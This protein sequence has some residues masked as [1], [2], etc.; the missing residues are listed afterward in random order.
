MLSEDY[1]TLLSNVWRDVRQ[2]IESLAEDPTERFAEWRGREVEFAREVLGQSL[3]AAQRSQIR[4]FFRNRFTTI[5]ASRRSSKTYTNAICIVIAINLYPCTLISLGPTERQVKQQLWQNVALIYQHAKRRGVHLLGKLDT[6]QLVVGPAHYALGFST[7]RPDRVQGAHA[8]ASP[9]LDDP[10]RDLTDDELEAIRRAAER[11][12]GDIRKLFY[13]LDEAA[14]IPQPIID[15]ILGST[16]SPNVHLMLTANPTRDYDDDHEFCRSFQPGSG[17]HRIKISP[18]VTEDPVEF[19][20]AFLRVPNWL[21]EPTWPEQCARKWGEDSP[22]Y[23]AY[24]AGNFASDQAGSQVIPLTILRDALANEVNADVGLHMG[25]DIARMGSDKS[26]ASLWRN[27]RQVAYHEWGKS[28]LMRSYEIVEDLRHKWGTR[29]ADGELIPIPG[30]NVHIDSIGVG[31][32]VVDRFFEAGIDVDAVDF[33]AAP[34]GDWLDLTDEVLFANRRAELHWAL[35]RAL[36]EGIAQIPENLG[37][38]PNPLFT[39]ARWPLYEFRLGAGATK[40]IIEPK[41]EIKKR[42]GRSPD[43]LDAALYAWSRSGGTLEVRGADW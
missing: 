8:G 38:R 24:V 6:T 5:R 29:G 17:Y 37:G 32:G 20:E 33:A 31:A 18:V 1:Q 3:W 11:G 7:D 27:G 39:E 26:V 12:E 30:E 40:L 14:G 43:H 22:L 36:Q 23:A 19:D 28:R 21:V 42:H 25:V 4:S 13:I 10:D 41:E 2:R 15:A 9:P 16:A 34:V 35:R